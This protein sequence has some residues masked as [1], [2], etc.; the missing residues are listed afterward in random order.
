MTMNQR[1]ETVE[2]YLRRGKTITKIPHVL[3]TIGSWRNSG[4]ADQPEKD[5]FK[6]LGVRAVSLRSLQPDKRF[7]TDDDDTKYWKQLDKRC[8]QLIKK[9]KIKAEKT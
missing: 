1:R 2:E 9:M 7:D 8:D 5:S 4:M 6:K 3:N